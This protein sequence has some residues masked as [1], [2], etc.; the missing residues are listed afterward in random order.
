MKGQTETL[1]KFNGFVGWKWEDEFR[2]TVATYKPNA[3]DAAVERMRLFIV[4]DFVEFLLEVV[5]R[6]CASGCMSM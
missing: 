4:T 5:T 6:N 3:E 1:M 2:K